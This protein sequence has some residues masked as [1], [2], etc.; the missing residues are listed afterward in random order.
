MDIKI[1]S[2]VKCNKI[3]IFM[4]SYNNNYK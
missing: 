1:A 2:R 3:R 4:A